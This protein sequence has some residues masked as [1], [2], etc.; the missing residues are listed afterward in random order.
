MGKETPRIYWDS[1][2]FIAIL[3]AEQYAPTCISILNEAK[4]GDIELVISALTMAETVRPR[5]APSP[6]PKKHR[7]K[8]LDFFENDYIRLINFDREIART[9]LDLC[10]EYDLHARD[11]LHLAAA[12][13]V[14][15]DAL[16]TADEQFIKRVESY[17]GGKL[18]IRKP[19]GKGQAELPNTS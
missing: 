12:L 10:W 13:A 4:A 2:C 15:C 9:S 18:L 1:C 6:L 8:V 16:E 3:N 7:T 14:D 19:I 5:G 17:T 11:A